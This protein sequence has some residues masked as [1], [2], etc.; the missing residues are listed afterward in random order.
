MLDRDT[1][2]DLIAQRYKPLFTRA[3]G[4]FSDVI[5]AWDT[6]LTRR[7]AIKKIET[8]ESFSVVSLEEARTA[9]LL[10]SP[11][12]VSVYDFEGGNRE[13]LIV[14]ENVDGPS[15][16]ELM[17][18]SAELLDINVLTTILEGIV[19]ALEYAHENQVLHLDIKPANILITQSGHIKVSDF[20][21]AE[22]A[23]SSGFG[24]VQGGTIGY[25]PPEQLSGGPV[26]ER[27]DLWGLASL[28]YQLLTGRNPFF[29]LSVRESLEYIAQENYALP[30]QLR[31]EL[32]GAVDEILVRALSPLKEN[33]QASIAEFWLELRPHL[34]KIG[35]G[36]RS[37]KA[38]AR[39]WAGKEASLLEASTGTVLEE[40]DHYADYELDS[41]L[42]GAGAGAEEDETSEQP[43]IAIWNGNY[44]DPYESES[45]EEQEEDSEDKEDKKK[46]DKKK[47]E[48]LLPPWQRLGSK[49]QGFIARCFCALAAA[50]M[51]W[52]AMSTLPY[53]SAPLAQAATTAA[54]NTGNPAPS[55]LDA[56]FT[57]RLGLM[58]LTFV[59]TLILPRV[60]SA[61][62]VVGLGLG[63]FFTG[64]WFIGI[65]VL[66][67]CLAWWASI[68]R[69]EL[70]D[71]AIFTLSPLLA[72]ISLPLL[73]PLLSGFFQNWRRALG[74]TALAC[75]V[76]SLLSLISYGPGSTFI[77][78]ILGINGAPLYGQFYSQPLDDL[79]SISPSL[80]QMPSANYLFMPLVNLLTSLEFW[81]IFAGWLGA[82]VVMSLLCSGKSRVKYTLA[83][84]LSTGI[85][86]AGY[87][88]PFFMLT[89]AN[90]MALLA[91]LLIRLVIVLAIILLLIVL[92]VQSKPS[93]QKS[94]GRKK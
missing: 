38:L 8:F 2:D 75:F 24:T 29:A 91:A 16:S 5:I 62:A 18:D 70:A 32:A 1:Q 90:N 3:R 52:I 7:V 61:I 42:A 31:P 78:A 53:L 23:G 25:M 68:G 11:N 46:K 92:G 27:T 63:I 87:L 60:G 35:P 89:A 82:S 66:A 88:L 48:K 54:A 9:A 79:L 84:L 26:D 58:L 56:A 37:L 76:C 40:A 80:L 74:S 69:R 20:G 39:A 57:I 33:R 34:G 19:A 59:I 6:R 30:S 50:G 55:L 86:A 15:L 17:K 67:G 12:I 65:L 14:M 44:D 71:S 41:T 94:K 4:G 13:T 45:A 36:R 43:D 85:V 64:N 28:S 93:M 72:V 81:C 10:S 22:L 47:E 21:L 51:V 83:A 77:D 49:G 73:T